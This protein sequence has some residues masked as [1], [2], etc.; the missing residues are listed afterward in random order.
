MMVMMIN[1]AAGDQRVMVNFKQF[2]L[3]N[4]RET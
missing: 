2:S 4:A 1:K 3:I